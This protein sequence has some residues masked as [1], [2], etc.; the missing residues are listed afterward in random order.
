MAMLEKWNWYREAFYSLGPLSLARL[1]L[2]K[3]FGSRKRLS[4]LTSKTL[5]HPVFARPGAS[6][7]LVF[8]QVF[9]E[10]EYRC[11]DA[12]K[13]APKLIIDCGANVGYSSVYFLS[14]FPSCSVIAVEPDP[15]NFEVLKHNLLSY[16]LRCDAIQAA[17]WPRAERLQIKKQL[18]GSEW[19]H[20]VEVANDAQFSVLSVTVPSLIAN[21][22]FKRI[23]ILKIDIEGAELELFK[24]DTEWLDHVDNIVIELH[25]DQCSKAFFDAVRPKKFDISTCGEL[26]VCLSTATYK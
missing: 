8:H 14:T 18:A 24:A 2:Q 15:D 17:I 11:L 5:A 19:G 13:D 6:D 3:R 9:V 23:S 26:T 12:I 20:T 1:Q 10:R 16:S 7:F 21:S 4:K 25:G 22:G